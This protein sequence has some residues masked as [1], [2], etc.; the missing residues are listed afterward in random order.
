[1]DKIRKPVS[2]LMGMNE[3]SGWQLKLGYLRPKSAEEEES[4]NK[5]TA[6]T[7]SDKEDSACVTPKEA[8][9][10]KPSKEVIS[11]G[12]AADAG[13]VVPA[14]PA[15]VVKK[16]SK[17]AESKGRAAEVVSMPHGKCT[18]PAVSPRHQIL[19]TLV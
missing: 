9:S 1:M 16:K 14:P 10:E 17:L 18:E 7:E 5:G 2:A 4:S 8:V 11:A 6:E 3:R 19:Q 13:K 12:A 15:E